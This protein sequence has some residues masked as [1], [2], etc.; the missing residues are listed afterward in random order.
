ME[1]KAYGVVDSIDTYWQIVNLENLSYRPYYKPL[2]K[3]NSSYFLRIA[4]KWVKEKSEDPILLDI[5]VDI[6]NKKGNLLASS[7][8]KPSILVLSQKAFITILNGKKHFGTLKATLLG[9]KQTTFRSLTIPVYE[10]KHFVYIVQVSTSMDSTQSALNT[11]KLILLLLLPVSVIIFGIIGVFL[12]RMILKPFDRII[13]TMHKITAEN[14]ELRLNIPD[15]NDELQK[16]TETFNG[17]LDRL[18][19]SFSY[20]RKLIDDISH[21]LK[22]PLAIIKGELEVAMKKARTTKEYK[23]IL[24]SNLEETNRIIRIIENLLLLS[25]LDNKAIK[26]KNEPVN[27]SKMIHT[28]INDI[29]IL[30]RRKHITID[31]SCDEKIIIKG[32]ELEIKRL[33]LNLIDNAIKYNIKKGNISITINKI[34]N[35]CRIKI[36][37]TGI[38][39]TQ[40]DL[41]HIFD[42]FYRSDINKLEKGFGL[43]LSIVK[44]IVLLHKG[45]IE[46]SSKI[47]KGTTFEIHFPLLNNSLYFFANLS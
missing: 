12:S 35:Y 5:V 44:S 36:S 25:R 1:I 2:S 43:G 10:N 15:T 38:G 31:V 3:I 24:S 30:A 6:F 9:K 20:Q 39:I 13:N 18:D 23:K 42:R 45:K 16:L 21:E 37:D 22:T 47:N 7:K 17:M 11:L 14:L 32:N 27:L 28:I 26:I 34:N 33:F 29:E 4:Q 40:N 41:K 46:V 8:Q 19:N